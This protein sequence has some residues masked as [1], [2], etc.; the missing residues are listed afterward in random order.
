MKPSKDTC[1][2][3]ETFAW[4]NEDCS[5]VGDWTIHTIQPE[6]IQW[7]NNWLEGAWEAIGEEWEEHSEGRSFGGECYLSL[8]GHGAG[9]WDWSCDEAA[10][11]QAKLE[12]YAGSKYL[13]EEMMMTAE[14]GEIY[15][16]G[17]NMEATA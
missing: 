12:S 6:I 10:Q 11:I 1:D 9:I 2:F 8:S 15:L 4:A 5:S 14:N 7:L 16:E 17:L 13:F 3:L